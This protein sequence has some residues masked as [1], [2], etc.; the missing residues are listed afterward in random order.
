MER[1]CEKRESSECL[2]SIAAPFASFDKSLASFSRERISARLE[3]NSESEDE[4]FT[5]ELLQR[6]FAVQHS[7]ITWTKVQ[8]SSLLGLLPK[9][10]QFSVDPKR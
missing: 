6:N 7:I 5:R 10:R 2:E 3:G 8:R 9:Q 4:L 1:N